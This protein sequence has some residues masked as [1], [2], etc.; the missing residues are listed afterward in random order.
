M[1][2]FSPFTNNNVTDVGIFRSWSD[3]SA[4]YISILKLC[5]CVAEYFGRICYFVNVILL[6]VK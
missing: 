1:L 6:N 3:S 2:Y 4:S 5:V